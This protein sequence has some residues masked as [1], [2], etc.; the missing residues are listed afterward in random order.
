MLDLNKVYQ[1]ETVMKIDVA[2]IKHNVEVLK[3]KTS[4]I[5]IAVIKENGYGMGLQQAYEIMVKSGLDYFAVTN[6]AEALALR[7]MGSAYPIL[8]MSPYQQQELVETLIEADITLMCNS[9][10]QLEL[11]QK[12]KQEKGLIA[13]VHLVVE[14]G[15]GRYGF[16]YNNLPDFTPYLEAIKIDGCYSHF[17]NHP[18]H[19]QN[20][21]NHFSQALA[22]LAAQGIKPEITHLSNSAALLSVGDAGFTAVRIGSALLG[23]AA[24]GGQVLQT[25][26]W[27]EAPVA[28]VVELPKGASVGYNATYHL[29]RDSRLGLVRAGHG[30]GLFLGYADAKDPSLIHRILHDIREKLQPSRY[31]I[32]G[33]IQ[34]KQVPVVGSSG[35]AHVMLDLTGTNFKEQDTVR[36]NCNPLLVHPA[37][38][39]EFI[40][41]LD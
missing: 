2:A 38:P 21:I 17:N 41:Q 4:S 25:A 7:E 27:M 40:N 16:R 5:I 12:I 39:K 35:I 6:A 29:K 18:K 26:V 31:Q 23:K 1:K 10:E 37:V 20:Q 13:K 14:T 3:T 11:F 9:V 24:R 30:D 33:I 34:G 36:F 32:Y 28:Q 8:L 15:M 22:K 19:Y